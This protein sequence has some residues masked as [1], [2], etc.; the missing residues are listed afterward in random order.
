MGWGVELTGALPLMLIL[1]G[2]DGDVDVELFCV[3]RAIVRN[4]DCRVMNL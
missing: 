1:D 4:V 2:R 3:E